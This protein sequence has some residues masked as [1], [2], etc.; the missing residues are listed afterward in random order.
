MGT[1]PVDVSSGEVTHAEP[2][3]ATQHTA[4]TRGDPMVDLA[5]LGT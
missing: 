1:S 2:V 4:K 5:A 3:A